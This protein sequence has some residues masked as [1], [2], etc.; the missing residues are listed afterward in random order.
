MPAYTNTST[1]VKVMAMD[2]L[3]QPNKEGGGN[4]NVVYYTYY[5]VT[6]NYTSAWCGID[7]FTYEV[8]VEF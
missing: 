5:S 8:N 7:W 1:H 2:L 3:E 4:C 6:K